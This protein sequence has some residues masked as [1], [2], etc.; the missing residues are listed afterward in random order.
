MGMTKN[1][2]E[3]RRKRVMDNLKSGKGHNTVEYQVICKMKWDD[4]KDDRR[5]RIA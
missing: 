3:A 4:E 5:K 1:Q 2:L